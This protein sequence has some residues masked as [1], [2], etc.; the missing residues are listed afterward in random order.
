MIFLSFT[1]SKS[2]TK[3][4]GLVFVT[5]GFGV[6]GI[7]Y[8]FFFFR[9]LPDLFSTNKV[10]ALTQLVIS[11]WD[12]WGIGYFYYKAVVTNPGKVPKNIIS[13]EELSQLKKQYKENLDSEF[14][15][16]VPYCPYCSSFKPPRTHHDSVMNQCVLKM[17]HYCPW[18]NNSVGFFNHKY[19]VLFTLYLWIGCI[20][21]FLLTAKAFLFQ[22]G[23]IDT[24]D[25]NFSENVILFSILCVTIFLSLSFI[26]FWQFFLVFTN[27]TTIEFYQRMSF[28]KAQRPLN[29][30]DFGF[31]NNFRDFFDLTR[32]QSLIYFLFSTKLPK[33]DG[34]HFHENH[35]NIKLDV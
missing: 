19:F 11:I 35:H 15:V 21:A 6:L 24:P 22:F 9:I 31:K 28:P 1:N 7:S 5:L 25:E 27:Q 16:Y 29:P 14:P 12:A 3:I 23:F 2:A 30:Y 4:L 33:G 18:I 8:Y 20:Y 26:L 32:N 17:E 34:M 10:F 13:E